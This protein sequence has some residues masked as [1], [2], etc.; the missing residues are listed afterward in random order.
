MF[1]MNTSVLALCKTAANDITLCTF[2]CSLLPFCPD[3]SDLPE[4]AEIVYEF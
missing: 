2:K 1:Q 4:N 3:V